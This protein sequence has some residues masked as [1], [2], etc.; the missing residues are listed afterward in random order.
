MH[1]LWRSEEGN[2]SPW[3]WSS[4]QSLAGRAVRALRHCC[5]SPSPDR[6]LETPHYNINKGKEEKLK[7]EYRVLGHLYVKA[8]CGG[9]CL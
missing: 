8:R 2:R 5:I 6:P 3:N 7:K 1:C 9:S 4:R